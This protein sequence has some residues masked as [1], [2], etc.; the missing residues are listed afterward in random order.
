[1][2]HYMIE[3]GMTLLSIVLFA[4]YQSAAE[5]TKNIRM[6]ITRPYIVITLADKTVF[7]NTKSSEETI[8]RYEQLL[9]KAG[10]R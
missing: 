3:G 10:D 5:I 4:N 8:D 6:S 7:Y 2:F 9:L 1:M